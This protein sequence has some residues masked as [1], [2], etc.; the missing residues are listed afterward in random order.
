MGDIVKGATVMLLFTIKKGK[1]ANGVATA[2]GMPSIQSGIYPNV[3]GIVVLAEPSEPFSQVLSQ[4]E[5]VTFGVDSIREFKFLEPEE[6]E[7]KA[8]DCQGHSAT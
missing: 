7:S 2:R 6:S 4:E 5:P 1:L 3:L 8:R